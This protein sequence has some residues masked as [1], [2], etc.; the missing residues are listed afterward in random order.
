M[1]HCTILGSNTNKGEIKKLRIIS[2]IVISIVGILWVL[3]TT[4]CIIYK[5]IILKRT[6]QSRVTD[7]NTIYVEQDFLNFA[8]VHNMYN[9]RTWAICLEEFKETW[10]VVEIETW[11][12][13]FHKDWMLNFLKMRLPNPIKEKWP[14]CKSPLKVVNNLI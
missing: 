9:I 7:H 5:C 4:L 14:L 11:N 3:V 6:R 8:E 10:D 1:I 2:I 12:H 13:I